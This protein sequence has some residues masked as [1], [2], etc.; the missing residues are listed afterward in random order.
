M[1]RFEDID[2]ARLGGVPDL[3]PANYEAEV[4]ASR[5]SFIARWN[6][7]RTINQA[8]P[9]ADTLF[10]ENNSTLTL[11]EECAWRVT[12]AK[13]QY[14]DAVRAVKLA[15]TWGIYLEHR[16]S[17]F[18]LTRRVI[19]SGNLQAV[20]PVP[21]ILE[22][23]EELR[24][25]RQM[26]VEAV[27]TAG[28]YGAYIWW[29]L[30]AHPQI[31]S[32]AVYGPESGLVDP[33]EVLVIVLD[34]RDDG[35]APQAVLDAVSSKLS[36]ATVRP[37]TDRPV[38]VEAAEIILYDVSV[39]LTV[40]PGPDNELIRQRALARVTAHVT[41]RHKAG[42]TV[43]VSGIAAAA[44]IVDEQGKALIEEVEVLLPVANIVSGPK[45]AAF[46]QSITVTTDVLNDLVL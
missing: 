27:S 34:K 24:R 17:E 46:A 37:L 32:V 22:S 35:T 12:L 33:G 7:K 30:E 9:A 3:F 36:A 14:N 1:S 10:L 8:L 18:G 26:A 31:K 25:R 5:A 21:A 16:A 40:L 29:A 4:D 43:T 13:Q 2:L 20:P 19:D 44:S 42:A 11:I 28:P 45:E 41:D 23:D 38:F 6:A 39:K 15:S